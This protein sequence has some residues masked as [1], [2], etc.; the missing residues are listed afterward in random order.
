MR[1]FVA[2][3]FMVSLLCVAQAQAQEKQGNL[4]TIKKSIE[5]NDGTSKR[6][7]VMFRHSSHK[8]VKC[9]T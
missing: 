6:M 7:Y 4:N 1:Y 2:V 3:L 5:L 8:D 9:R